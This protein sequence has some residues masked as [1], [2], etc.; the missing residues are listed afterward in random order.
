MPKMRRY[1]KTVKVQ[2]VHPILLFFGIDDEKLLQKDKGIWTKI[3]D[4]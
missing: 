4:F 3:E 2:E 1:F